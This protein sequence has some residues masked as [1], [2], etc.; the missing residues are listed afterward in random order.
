MDEEFDELTK[1]IKEGV[2]IA[3]GVK[4]ATDKLVSSTQKQVI[5]TPMQQFVPASEELKDLIFVLSGTSDTGRE[6]SIEAT[7]DSNGIANFEN[8]PLGSYIVTEKGSSVPYAYMTADAEDVTVN[9]AQTT[10]IEI[11]NAEKTGTIKVSKATRKMK[12]IANITF[13]LHGT[14]DSGRD[15]LQEATTD[16][17][18]LANFEKIPLGTYTLTEKG[19]SVPYGYLTADDE[20]VTVNYA[21]K[22]DVNVFNL[23]DPSIPLTNATDNTVFIA[24]IIM[25]VS[26]A[27]FSGSKVIRIKTIQAKRNDR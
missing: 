18:G 27:V 11:S 9:Y 22:I 24:S 3:K 20:E 12:D 25:L 2:N 4:H 5:N 23:E 7:T 17:K 14:S 10:N 13:I 26:L 15:I 16:S 6:I 1:T 21:Q 19:A 8:V